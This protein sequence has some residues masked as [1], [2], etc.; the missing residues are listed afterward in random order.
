MVHRGAAGGGRKPASDIYVDDEFR[1]TLE[2]ARTASWTTLQDNEC[3]VEILLGGEVELV[4]QQEEHD[5]S[6]VG[7]IIL[8][9]GR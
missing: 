2:L 7:H 4:Y 5:A 6:N 9:S 1:T 8:K 3:D